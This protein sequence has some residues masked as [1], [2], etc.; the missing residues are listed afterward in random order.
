MSERCTVLLGTPIDDVTLPEA[1]DRIGT[2]VDHGRATA[3][4]HQVVTV[5]V[6]F[7]VNASRDTG[8]RSILQHSDLAI[9]DG[10]GIVWGARI[11]GVPVRQRTPGADLVP[12]LAERAARDGWRICLFGGA[13]GVA[14]RASQLLRER[15][16]GA[17]VRS[18]E[19]PPIAADAA[20]NPHILEA[21]RL[22]HAD[23]VAVALGNPK[24]ER[25]IARHGASVGAPVYVGIGGSL[26]FLTGVT[27]RAPSWMQRAGLEWVHRAISQP[28]RL[29]VRY[30]RDLAL[31]T[32][33][34]VVQA[35]RG[36]P[37]R[38]PFVVVAQRV[39]DRTTIDLR[40]IAKLDNVTVAEFVGQLRQ[41]WRE[42]RTVELR[43]VSRSLRVSATHFGIASL[44]DCCV[45]VGPPSAGTLAV[46]GGTPLGEPRS[47][48][49]VR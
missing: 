32:P 25:W 8:I 13:P 14:E 20:T 23:I 16:R 49:D 26:D 42:R 47:P 39:G 12:A 2:M 44:L 48:I 22:V 45:E 21:L 9:P 37:R 15:Y 28:R 29:A 30:G 1:L 34:L 27:R 41:A 40:G 10:M 24:Q 3:Q 31:F 46:L 4:V 6:D 33:G 11:L 5:N 43:G 19:A 35:L 36:R 7:V 17:D 38:R 18:M